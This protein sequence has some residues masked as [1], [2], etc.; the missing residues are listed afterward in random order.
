MN[1]KRLTALISAVLSTALVMISFSGTGFLSVSAQTPQAEIKKAFKKYVAMAGNDA[2]PDK[3]IEYINTQISPYTVSLSSDD[4]Y[5]IYHAVDGVYDE[6][7]SIYPVNI[8][9]YNGYMSVVLQISNGESESGTVGIIE[10]IPYETENLGTLTADVYSADNTNFTTD[11]SGNIIG[12]SGTA[13]KLIIPPGFTGTVSLKDCEGKDGVKVVYIG[14]SSARMKIKVANYSFSGWSSLRAVVLPEKIY[15]SIGQYGFANNGELKYVLMPVGINGSDGSG[16]TYGELQTGAFSGNPQLETVHYTSS[17]EMT[18]TQYW[19]A[20]FSGTAIRDYY[21]P[22]WFQYGTGGSQSSTFGSN[23]SYTEGTTVIMTREQQQ[24]ATFARAAVL[25]QIAA[26][27]LNVNGDNAD[28][29]KSEIDAAYSSKISGVTSEW[30]DSL[31]TSLVLSYNG[32]TIS[33]ACNGLVSLEMRPGANLRLDEPAGLRF[34]ANIFGLEATLAASYVASVDLGVLICPTDYILL[35]DFTEEAL[36]SEN[37]AYLDI[38]GEYLQQVGN[39]DNAYYTLSAVI[40]G[41]SKENYNRL[42]SARAYADITYIDGTLMRVYS[43]YDRELNSERLY[44]IAKKVLTNSSELTEEQT[45]YL[46]MVISSVNTDK[47]AVESAAASWI[48]PQKGGSDAQAEELR[49]QI[50]NTGNGTPDSTVYTGTTYYISPDGSDDYS[51]TDESCPWKT[52]KN[53]TSVRLNAGDKVLFKRSGVYRGCFVAVSGVYYGSYGDGDKPCIYGSSCNYAEKGW[54]KYSSDIWMI[55]GVGSGLNDDAGIVVF[56]HGEKAGVKKTELSALKA[57][58]DFYYDSSANKVYVLSLVNPAEKYYSIEIGICNHLISI[59]G[60][61]KNVTFENLTLKYTG[62]HGISVLDGAENIT[63]KNCEIGFVGGS[64]MSGTTTRYGNGVEFWNACTNVCVENCWIF[65]IYDSALTN[66]GSISNGVTFTAE[67]VTFK[68]NLVEYSALASIEY[69]ASGGSDSNGKSNLMK[70]ITY[71][72]NILRFAGCGWGSIERASAITYHIYGGNTTNPASNFVISNNIFDIS[73]Y[74]LVFCGTD[75]AGVTL[76]TLSG[77]TYIQEQ[78]GILG[79]YGYNA[80]DVYYFD[81][82]VTESIKKIFKDT[83]A[84]VLVCK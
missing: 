33:V 35:T 75:N 6:G 55:S 36:D 83:S 80:T 24:T 69:W 51:G 26:E 78:N 16:T 13:E 10:K 65:Q 38:R 29:V 8:K 2:E 70:D 32:N 11:N 59:S 77:N 43:D 42:Y 30:K 74:G 25:A 5:F 18:S 64:Y 50:L 61:A 68:N 3:M 21:L 54:S 44:S 76:P 84:T 63:V 72:G 41:I 17:P 57:E 34:T 53:L 56:N 12:Y 27:I 19:G 48:N 47:P 14:G 60:T 71:T 46:N 1:T 28:T 15:G 7:D 67:N 58:G 62:A 9:G 40:S 52:V 23:P 82:N 31:Y 37:K 39:D 79:K 4:D 73:K 66:Q 22:T 49:T 20:V 45:S 81:E